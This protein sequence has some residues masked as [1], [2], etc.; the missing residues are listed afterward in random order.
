M[1]HLPEPRHYAASVE[2]M[3]RPPPIV[4]R[5]CAS[6]GIRGTAFL[7]LPGYA[8]TAAHCV[9]D[10]D[11][12]AREVKLELPGVEYTSIPIWRDDLGGSHPG[13][14]AAILKIT[15]GSRPEIHLKGPPLS[16]GQLPPKQLPSELHWHSFG[17]PVADPEQLGMDLT[18]VIAGV[19]KGAGFRR[20]Q[21]TC[22]Q[23]GSEGTGLQGASGAPVTVN[24]HAVAMISR[25][26]KPFKQRI[27]YATLLEDIFAEFFRWAAKQ[28]PSDLKADI[29]TLYTAFG[30]VQSIELDQCDR[31][32]NKYLASLRKRGTAF[33][34][35][36]VRTP[37]CTTGR[38]EDSP[39]DSTYVQA[40]LFKISD[41]H[42]FW[43]DE[44]GCRVSQKS[45]NGLHDASLNEVVSQCGLDE[46]GRL[47]LLITGDAGAGKTTLL[48]YIGLKA[49][50]A[51]AEIGLPEPMLP[52]V[53]SLPELAKVKSVDG[54]AEWLGAARSKGLEVCSP[55]LDSQFFEEFPN[56]LGAQWLLLFD[57]FDEVPE[58]VRKDLQRSLRECVRESSIHWCLTSRPATSL[59]DPIIDISQRWHGVHSFKIV[60]WTEAELQH[61]AVSLLGS[62]QKTRDF[63]GQFR[64]IAL[65]RST[66]TPLLTLI[67]ICVY[68]QS[69]CK[70]PRSK[71]ELYDLFIDDAILRG[72]QR[73]A[74]NTPEWIDQDDREPLVELLS[75]LALYSADNPS[76]DRS[77]DLDEWFR[78][79]LKKMKLATTINARKRTRDFLQHVAGGSGLLLIDDQGRWRW[80]HSTVRDYLAA[81]AIANGPQ[82]G[83]IHRL[84]NFENS[85]WQEIIVYMMAVLSARHRRNPVRF[86]DV[87]GL[88]EHLIGNSENC[89][90]LLYIALAEGAAVDERMEEF[91]IE[92]LVHGAVQ[93]GKHSECEEYDQEL[94]RK[95]RSPVELLLKLSDRPAA[96]NG[97]VRIKN[98]ISIEPWM[99]EKADQALLRLAR[100]AN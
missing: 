92:R 12:E 49:L 17:Y 14:D 21:L 59:S 53:L 39:L 70:L 37:R 91:V 38:L 34:E 63:L 35:Q 93:L 16:V 94:G 69:S 82:E 31:A 44:T 41:V 9:F 47:Q 90:L 24:G 71:T 23:F 43:T 76:F 33:H 40:T 6:T 75:Q 20:L 13:L 15:G 1:R 79:N 62:E 46:G 64:F 56:R 66:T 72:L 57:G 78:T 80:W 25:N 68:E 19:Q 83:Q 67:A 55:G 5:A 48:N 3:N 81:V 27:V 100:V 8:L 4:F 85:T 10:G 54:F 74:T 50:F 51:P 32:L 26:P 28:F 7:L 65:D 73:T 52:L 22:D 11:V 98:D 61:F 97:L 45:T 95:G 88:F 99:R 89:G 60:P 18:G 42:D 58:L 77:D 86:P 87:T 84:E 96:L 30:I 36:A 2:S 29:E